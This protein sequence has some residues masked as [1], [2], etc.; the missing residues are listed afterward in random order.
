MTSFAEVPWTDELNSMKRT[1]RLQSGEK[2]G[3]KGR[4]EGEGRCSH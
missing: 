4:Q 2:N 1:R 3:D